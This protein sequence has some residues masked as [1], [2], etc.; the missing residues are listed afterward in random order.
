MPQR[1]HAE[2]IKAWADGAQ[3]E[4]CNHFGAWVAVDRP[5]WGEDLKYRVKPDPLAVFKEAH[6]AG[7]RVDFRAPG[8]LPGVGWIETSPGATVWPEDLEYRIALPWQD[9]RDAFDRGEPIEVWSTRNG[10]FVLASNPSWAPCLEYRV[11]PKITE[12]FEVLGRSWNA[13]RPWDGISA[14]PAP[15]VLPRITLDITH[16]AGKVIN[17]SVKEWK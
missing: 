9:E 8:Q 15:L 3:I 14:R 10:K 12:T 6:A 13:P 11:A 2:L 4:V 17:V 7:E 5:I 1:K 16:Q